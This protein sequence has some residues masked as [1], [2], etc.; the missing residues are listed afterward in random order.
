MGAWQSGSADISQHGLPILDDAEDVDI[1]ARGAI[2][3]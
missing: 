3:F 1:V 2:A